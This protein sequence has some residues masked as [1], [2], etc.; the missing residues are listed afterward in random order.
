MPEAAIE[1]KKVRGRRKRVRQDAA[2]AP[3]GGYRSA[4]QVINP[5]KGFK[6]AAL[7]VD[8]APMYKEDGY[9]RV[10]KSPGSP[11]LRWDGG[12]DNGPSSYKGHTLYEISEKRHAELHR[13]QTA[14]S[15][16]RM[17]EIQR[18]A[19]N[20]SFTGRVGGEGTFSSRVDT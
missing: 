19:R 13:E 18:T 5:R 6:Y 10:E 4:D 3:A 20:G 1:V 16:R 9:V 17:A 11:R 12:D 8:K 7:T 15:S 2:P 14:V